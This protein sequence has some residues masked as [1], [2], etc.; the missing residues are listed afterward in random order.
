MVLIATYRCN[1]GYWDCSTIL[2][3]IVE[4]FVWEINSGQNY[5]EIFYTSVYIQ[6]QNGSQRPLEWGPAATGP[7][8]N[9][10][11]VML[12]SKPSRLGVFDGLVVKKLTSF[13][14]FFHLLNW[15]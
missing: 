6:S 8:V 1:F 13:F 14:C 5:S 12:F 9:R 10:T 4:I 7:N 2:A 15:R 3:R 11:L